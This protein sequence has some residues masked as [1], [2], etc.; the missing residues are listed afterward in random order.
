MTMFKTLVTLMRGRA[1][2]AA[3]DLA[4]RNALTILDQQMRDAAQGLDL[5]RRALAVAIA[6]DEAEARRIDAAG[7][8]IAD[9][10]SRAIAA[11]NG[12]REDLATEAAEAMSSLTADRLAGIEARKTFAGE[13]AKLKRDVAGAEHRLSQLD[14]GRR[15]AR[16]AEAVRR[17]RNDATGRAGT[18]GALADAEATLA[19]L[20]ARQQESAA[21]EKAL[22]EM[23]AR[24]HDIVEVLASAGFGARTSPSADEILAGLK[25]KATKSSEAA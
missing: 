16:A 2:E 10:E 17:M 21:A 7:T 22:Q 14:R 13:I 12:G 23:T 25:A 15:V 1:H 11:L 8:R 20:R 5:A 4:D 9:L 3:E 18:D 6:S 24:P 19:R